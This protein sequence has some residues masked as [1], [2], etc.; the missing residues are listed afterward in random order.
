[1][2]MRRTPARRAALPFLLLL[3]LLLA[4]P[5]AAQNGAQAPSAQPQSGNQAGSQAA[6]AQQGIGGTSEDPAK[7]LPIVLPVPDFD[8]TLFDPTALFACLCQKA[9]GAATCKKPSEYN[10]VRTVN[11]VFL[12]SSF[13]GS[14]P[15]DFYCYPDGTNLMLS[16]SA[17]GKIRITIPFEVDKKNQCV[18]ATVAGGMCERTSTVSCCEKKRK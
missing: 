10:L 1:M 11:G 18:K 5:A 2:P 15:H 7:D 14:A 13:Y 16:G 4:A 12:Y 6:P 9:L 8:E 17:W 3:L